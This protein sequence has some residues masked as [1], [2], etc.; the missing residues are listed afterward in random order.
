[1]NPISERFQH[2]ARYH[3]SR[4][5]AYTSIVASHC[6][7]SRREVWLLTVAALLHDIGKIVVP[8]TILCKQGMLSRSEWVEAQKHTVYGARMLRGNSD[9]LCMSRLVALCHHE[10]WDGSGYP[11]GLKGSDIPLYSQIVS[12]TDVFDAL[13]S[14]RSYKRP[15]DMDHAVRIIISGR[16]SMFAPQVVDG[17]FHGLEAVT[18]ALAVIRWQAIGG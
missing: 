3:H 8:G 4:V 15:F 6:G 16:G 18:E 17:F 9:V 5:A 10:R 7:L 13:T 11:Q 1:M 14:A 2:Q 12:I